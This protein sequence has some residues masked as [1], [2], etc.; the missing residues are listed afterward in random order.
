[1]LKYL[2]KAVKLLRLNKEGGQLIL[3]GMRNNNII[4][5][6][7]LRY[8]LYV[9][10]NKIIF[11]SIT[12]KN[13]VKQDIR[14]MPYGQLINSLPQGMKNKIHREFEPQV[15]TNLYALQMKGR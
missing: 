4:Q 3:Q 11:K 15:P 7:D 12:T 6:L 5:D 10:S 14:L 2:S 1:M 8:V 9:C 13:N